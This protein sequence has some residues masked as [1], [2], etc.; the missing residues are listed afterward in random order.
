MIKY[1]YELCLDKCTKEG[2]GGEDEEQGY[3]KL[4]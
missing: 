1:T 2:E 3:K 4:A